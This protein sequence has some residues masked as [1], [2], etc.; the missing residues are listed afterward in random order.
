M[1]TGDQGVQPE[2]VR[3]IAD[4]NRRL[5]EAER[6]TIRG[7]LFWAPWSR[8]RNPSWLGIATTVLTRDNAEPWRPGADPFL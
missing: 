7:G 4:L 2:E 3:Y 8:R 5:D 1:R 6:D